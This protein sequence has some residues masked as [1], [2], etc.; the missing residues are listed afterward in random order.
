[1]KCFSPPS[2][3]CPSPPHPL[4]SRLFLFSFF[5]RFCFVV[6]FVLIFSLVI[7]TNPSTHHPITSLRLCCQPLTPSLPLVYIFLSLSLATD[8][9]S[10]SCDFVFSR[11]LLC[12]CHTVRLVLTNC[13]ILP[14]SCDLSSRMFVLHLLSVVFLLLFLTLFSS[15]LVLVLSIATST[16]FVGAFFSGSFRSNNSFRPKPSRT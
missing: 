13:L 8:P 1:M 12:S 11:S 15:L 6:R 9:L 5:C 14:L 4:P 7:S 16:A 10:G 3:F 2:A